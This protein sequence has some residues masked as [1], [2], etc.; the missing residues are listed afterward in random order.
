M[1][2]NEIIDI[3][4]DPKTARR[5]RWRHLVRVGVPL[6][7]V[8]LVTSAIIAVA[9]LSYSS[10]RRDALA[11]SGELIDALDNRVRT[12]VKGYMQPAVQAV[13]TL[14]GVL[15][16]GSLTRSS[17]T[18]T[19]RFALQA[20]KQQSQ[21]S[22]LFAG[23]DDGN[24]L[25][26]QRTADETFD[27]KVVRNAPS[28]REVQF[29]R[30]DQSGKVIA[31]ER[32]PTDMFDPRLRPWFKGAIADKGIFWTDLY[33]FFSAQRPGITVSEPGQPDAD[34][35]LALVV[36]ADIILDQLSGFLRQIEIGERGRVMIVDG[37]GYLIA[38]PDPA[39]LIRR[40][41]G[42]LML[43]H[44]HDLKEPVISEIYD[45]LRVEGPGRSIMEIDGE[46]YLV[47][48]SSLEEFFGRQWSLLLVAPE[49]DFV[50]FVAENNRK[51]LLYSGGIAALAATL[52]A[53]LGYQSMAA[54]RHAR[55]V[56]RREEILQERTSALVDIASA[57][58][59]FP[60]DPRRA[61]QSVTERLAKVL[62]AHRVSLW[63]VERGREA[64]VCADCFDHE[65]GGH[66]AGMT[67]DHADCPRFLPELLA[68]EG[69]DVTDAAEDPRTNDLFAAYLEPV[70]SRGILC[71]PIG[72]GREPV[73]FIWVEDKESSE[74]FEDT[75]IVRAAAAALALPFAAQYAEA[76]GQGDEHGGRAQSVPRPALDA[77]DEHR[78][79]L[80]SADQPMRRAAL[81]SERHRRLAEDLRQ[82]SGGEQ[83]AVSAFTEATVLVLRLQ[84]DVALA[85]PAQGESDS[86]AIQQIVAAFEHAAGVSEIRYL[87][88]LGQEIVAADG[89][90]GDPSV[91]AM[92]LAELSLVMQQRCS[93]LLGGR[94][95]SLEFTL[96]L[97]TGPIMGAAIGFGDAPYNLWGE[98]V[99]I[100]SRMAE[101]A[102][103]GTIQ[104]SEMAYRHLTERFFFR[105]RGSF[106]LDGYGDMMT[107]TLRGRL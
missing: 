21:L 25:M 88:I 27:T 84:D 83:R 16:G 14:A 47:A 44:L 11:L 35:V 82:V 62:E 73:G 59:A 8:L 94:R 89:F 55:A 56:A 99:R 51:A 85:G 17:E 34:G 80:P 98:A 86:C 69:I 57:A 48:A 23:D 36:G 96:G 26:V 10:N 42:E 24:F 33:V 52:A 68:G 107:F 29:T 40:T 105:Q 13:T 95:E 97:D 31:I 2:R 67:I 38:Y 3:D 100:A 30:R 15:P 93:E 20:L 49:D 28:K 1:A 54:D 66:T 4:I 79:G 6:I 43:S 87:K 81:S 7:G 63:Q 19:E 41:N 53:L 64:I 102:P 71:E 5:L 60:D 18:L 106:Y 70:G 91:A 50:G 101:T 65:S 104:V 9:F 22:S 37:E 39:Q 77:L 12:E 58:S 92:R 76:A 72:P 61:A 45:R 32:D 103:P 74:H 75:Q 90:D 46:R 78:I